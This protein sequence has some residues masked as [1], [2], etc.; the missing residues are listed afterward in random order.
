MG[1]R[2]SI[3]KPSSTLLQERGSASWIERPRRLRQE[4]ATVRGKIKL[5]RDG[6]SN[7]AQRLRQS[8]KRRARGLTNSRQS[9]PHRADEGELGNLGRRLTAGREWSARPL[10]RSTDRQHRPGATVLHRVGGEL[11]L[12]LVE[13]TRINDWSKS[14]AEMPYAIVQVIPQ[15]TLA[16]EPAETDGT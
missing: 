6:Q 2:R 13:A 14:R 5:L 8:G 11:A 9:T 15:K 1:P 16:G 12:H 10:P 7:Q 4:V 3:S